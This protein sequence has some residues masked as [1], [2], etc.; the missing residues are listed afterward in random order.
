MI[1]YVGR[2]SSCKKSYYI[3]REDNQS[4]RQDILEQHAPRH[5]LVCG[6][7][8]SRRSS[9]P[10]WGVVGGGGGKIDW[11]TGKKNDYL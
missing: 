10:R 3:N 2:F 8:V 4:G 7:L 1:G 9:C 11:D 6:G 5:Q